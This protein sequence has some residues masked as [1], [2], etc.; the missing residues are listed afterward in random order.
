MYRESGD[1][2]DGSALGLNRGY[3]IIRHIH[4]F[5]LTRGLLLRDVYPKR[6]VSALLIL[7]M[8][9]LRRRPPLARVDVRREHLEALLAH[10]PD[11]HLFRERD[12][13]RVCGRRRRRRLRRGA[14]QLGARAL[15][16]AGGRR[17]GAVG[18]RQGRHVVVVAVNNEVLLLISFVD[19]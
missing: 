3:E 2:K 13:G 9:V 12:D 11:D 5:T 14:L 19:Y 4:T 10:L 18:G 8:Q 15:P 16:G 6:L 1:D 17:R 7:R